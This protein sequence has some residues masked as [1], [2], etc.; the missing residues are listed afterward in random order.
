MPAAQLEVILSS[1]YRASNMKNICSARPG[2]WLQVANMLMLLCMGRS[3]SSL[4]IKCDIIKSSTVAQPAARISN[5]STATDLGCY[6]SSENVIRAKLPVEVNVFDSVT[7][8]VTLNVSGIVSCVWLLPDN[9]TPCRMSQNWNSSFVISLDLVRMSE[10]HAGE[11]K[12]LINNDNVSFSVHI[13]L[14]VKGKP[15]KPFFTETNNIVSCISEGYPEPTIYWLLCSSPHGRCINK[16]GTHLFSG[17]DIY[18]RRRVMNALDSRFLQDEYILCCVAN[19]FGTECTQLYTIDLNSEGLLPKIFVK[20]GEPFI[21][22]CRAMNE[23]YKFRVEWSYN[24]T[25]QMNRSNSGI[26]TCSSTYLPSKSVHVIL[27]DKGFIHL[28]TSKEE[29][30]IDQSKEFCFHVTFE[31]YPAARCTWLY[32]SN[33]FPCE[34]ATVGTSVAKFCDHKYMTGEYT[35]Y[36]ENEDVQLHKTFI[37]NLLKKPEIFATSLQDYLSCTAS[38]N[39]LAVWSWKR[40]REDLSNCTDDIIDGFS[41]G[42]AE[43]ISDA[44]M[45]R[46]TLYIGNITGTF[47]ICCCANNSVGVT[48]EKTPLINMKPIVEQNSYFIPVISCLCALS[49]FFLTV[50][51]Y[52]K[53][54][55]KNLYQSQLQM[56][57]YIGPSDNEYIYIDFSVLEYDLKWEFPRENLEFGKVLG[58][59]AFG[60]VVTATAYGIAKPGVSLQV[61]VKMLKENAD[62]SEKDALMSELKMMTQ[63]GHHQNIVNMMGACTTAGPIYLIFEYCLHGD[64]LNYLRS[65]RETFHKTWTDVVKDHNFSF[66]HNFTQ[67]QKTSVRRESLLD[68]GFYM[69][70]NRTLVSGDSQQIGSFS[71]NSE[72]NDNQEQQIKYENTRCYDEEDLHVLTFEDLLCFS[73]QVAKGMEFL[74]SKLCIHRD[75]AARNILITNGKVAKICDFGLARDIENDSNYV[76]KGNAR[77]PVKWMAPESIFEG[78]YTIKSDVWSYGI[79]LWE[80][81]SLGINPYPGI[82][83]N[84]H[85]YK[86]LQSG[87]KMEQPFYATDEIYFL[88]Q[89]CW[90]FDSRKRLSFPQL[91]SF[92]GYQIS[93][94]EALVY[95][96]MD[97]PNRRD[98]SCLKQSFKEMNS[99]SLLAQEPLI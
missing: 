57:Q 76:V 31:A 81:F 21:I 62:G 15:R 61:A 39:P 86:L 17:T 95:Q 8:E 69:A 63:I 2:F 49:I 35:F 22:R 46:S 19:T 37:L 58:S 33:H 80:I 70:E 5:M 6:W 90:A 67:H 89:S 92:L 38:A 64:L 3:H 25:D 99:P 13:E 51:I 45:S 93:N 56:I 36:I 1:L 9:I 30:I 52:N 32:Q 71:L 12:L 84:A 55:K 40:S 65:E 60:R 26:Y 59:G 11:Y 74:E 91:V 94:M 4:A 72:Q 24:S 47:W 87:F 42:L 77:L 7:L 28:N 97:Q 44:W 34:N 14:K 98:S 23:T 83:V 18:G 54:Q 53:S 20:V 68:N 79:L 50:L 43:R 73:Y 41:F 78:I 66:Y 96:N 10:K 75:L 85:F 82:Q 29:Y 88:M 48:C 27:S 16:T